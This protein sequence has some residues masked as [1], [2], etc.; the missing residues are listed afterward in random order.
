MRDL[1]QPTLPFTLFGSPAP[2]AVRLPTLRTPHPRPARSELEAAFDGGAAAAG[3]Q[4]VWARSAEDI[5]AAQRLR[6]Q[7]FA[8]EMGARLNNLPGTPPGLDRDL[9]DAHCEHLLVRD[10]EGE[11]IGTYRVLTP[12]AARRV[13]G[14]YSETE[15]DLT[16]LRPL[17]PRMAEL[18][19]SCV[20]PAHRQGGAIMTLWGALAAFMARNGL[21]TMIGCASIGMRDGG[22]AAASIWERLRQTH[23]APIEWQVRPRLPLPVEELDRQ[24]PVEIPP[25][26]KGYLRCGAKVLGPPAWDPDFHT[27]DLPILMRLRDLPARYRRHF[28]GDAAN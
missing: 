18:G 16:R 19:R 21:D 9:F 1:P 20:H 5:E 28:L 17:M 2:R 8:Q 25:L 4:A 6:W 22:H 7:V 14:W 10:A 12:A 13:G 24:R 3:L 26:I 23:L 15:F 27:A 11:A